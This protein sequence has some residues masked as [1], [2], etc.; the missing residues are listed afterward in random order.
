MFRKSL[1]AVA[2]AGA[3]SSATSG[4]AVADEI[5]ASQWGRTLDSAELAVAL[6]LGYYKQ[7]GANI[8]GIVATRGG[9]TAIRSL[10]AA[11]DKIGYAIV[12]LSAAVDAIR[13]GADVRIINTI[14]QSA[15]DSVL[16]AMPKSPINTM[17][18]LKGKSIAIT[19][20]RGWSEMLAILAVEKSGLPANSVKRP[21][22]GSLG[23]ALTG[24]KDGVVQAAPFIEPYLSMAR[25]KYKVVFD[26]ATLP[27]MVRAVGIA[28]TAYI[29]KHPDRLRA[30]LKAR[31][32]AVAKMYSDPAA[33]AKAV[34]KYFPRVPEKALASGIAVMAKGNF[35]SKD[36]K[37][38]IAA[39]DRMLDG[40]RA[41]G[42]LEGAV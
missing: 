8:T 40:L 32:M 29:K 38:D 16:V 14:T 19:R 17:K 21:A 25:S 33:S 31:S 7:A 28:T 27:P 41:I 12:S 35:W 42:A 2:V 9:G 13:K 5:I 6:E 34:K 20:P 10:L 23:A 18:D 36:G 26:G 4:S 15:A 1:L 37:F 11:G 30:I 3:F 22:L 39:M 24:L